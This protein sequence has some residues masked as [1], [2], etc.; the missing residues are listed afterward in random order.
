MI[1]APRSGIIRPPLKSLLDYA[2][3]GARMSQLRDAQIELNEVKAR[4]PEQVNKDALIWAPQAGPQTWLL[5]CPV[6]DVLFGGAR[7]GGKTDAL[8]GDWIAHAGQHGKNAFGMIVRKTTNSLDEVIKRTQQLFPSLGA[9][10]WASS[11]TWVFSNGATLKLRWMEREIDSDHYRGHQYTWLGFDEADTWPD[12]NGIDRLRA[13]LRSAAGVPCLIRLTANP[14]GPGH[15]WLKER[16]VDPAPPL[17]VFTDERKHVERVFIPS[18]LTDNRKLLDADPTYVD[19]LYSSGPAHLVRAWLD[20]DWNASASESFFTVD[21]LLLNGAPVPYPTATDRVY[22]V[23]DTALKDGVEHD[24]TAVVYYALNDLWRG[25]FHKRV[26]MGKQVSI[27]ENA[28]P[29]TILDW[30]IR[31]IEGSLLVDW[32]PSVLKRCEHLAAQ[33]RARFGSA[34]A[35]IEDKGSGIV[36]LQQARRG[37]WRHRVHPISNQ[38]VKLGKEERVMHVGQFVYGGYTKI[39]QYAWDKNTLYKDQHKNHFISQVCGFHLGQKTGPRDLLDCFTYGNAI[40]LGNQ[41]GE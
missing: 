13:T 36:L 29:L 8:L 16:Y 12:P 41:K 35:W 5:S 19:R 10:W 15:M 18:R 26:Q 28:V 27:P 38:L 14:G 33:T 20:G 4:I 6:G 21:S 2:A 22:A 32:L 9:K 1:I 39:S 11:K 7:G 3:E 34:G 37:A 31:Q 25:E 24:G 30:E 23:I 17:T 40:G